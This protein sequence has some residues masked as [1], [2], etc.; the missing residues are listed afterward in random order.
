MEKIVWETENQAAQ[1]CKKQIKRTSL[2]YTLDGGRRQEN[3]LSY[4]LI[5]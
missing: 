4:I 2:K 1:V 5:T 3:R